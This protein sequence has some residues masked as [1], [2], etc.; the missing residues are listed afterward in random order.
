MEVKDQTMSELVVLPIQLLAQAFV[1]EDNGIIQIMQ[2]LDDT[3]VVRARL[4]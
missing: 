1:L 2:V 4:Q 3:I